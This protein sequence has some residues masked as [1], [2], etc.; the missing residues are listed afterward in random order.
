MITKAKYGL[1]ITTEGGLASAFYPPLYDAVLGLAARVADLDSFLMLKRGFLAVVL[2]LPTA[3]YLLWRRNCDLRA[4]ILVAFLPMFIQRFD[5][6][7]KT[8]E[9][10]SL[11]LSLAW[12]L[13]WLLPLRHI[14][15][16]KEL[17]TAILVGVFAG[18][19]LA[20]YYYYF[21]VYA[22]YLI[23]FD[24]GGE[25]YH[26]RFSRCLERVKVLAVVG[27][28]ALV[29]SAWYWLPLFQD[30]ARFG[31]AS[32]QNRYF[33]ID[34]AGFLQ[35]ADLGLLHVIPIFATFLFADQSELQKRLHYLVLSS[36]AWIALSC[37][38]ALLGFPLLYVKVFLFMQYVGSISLIVGVV[39]IFRQ[40]RERRSFWG[41][42]LESALAPTLV[43][44]ALESLILFQHSPELKT[45]LDTPEPK[46]SQSEQTEFIQ[47][48]RGRTVLTSDSNLGSF[49]PVHIFL[50]TN[51]HYS[52][53][54]ARS[55][56]RLEFLKSLIGLERGHE[57]A[58][59]LSY[60]PFVKVDFVDIRNNGNFV[61][62]RDN[63]PL[64][65]PTIV[66]RF[67]Y[68]PRALQSEWFIK[69]T[70]EIGDLRVDFLRIIP[71]PFEIYKDFGARA[72]KIARDL[73]LVPP[74]R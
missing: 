55:E 32:Y 42:R 10:I 11:Y 62:S 4:A 17:V 53:A 36:F 56:Q 68:V 2:V 27:I 18:L 67:G 24:V 33:P 16:R 20:N 54:A 72:T 43:I 34:L 19:L 64:W 49:L 60:N 35:G 57:L 38:I 7:Y 48:V 21:F 40:S 41:V 31:L 9:I 65:P 45:A 66:E 28:A 30:I 44:V 23:L 26:R 71:P 52:H 15:T 29:A 73:N 50:E 46:F 47:K 59:L 6:L 37:C 61:L 3:V 22:L 74:H 70:W 5:L 1:P 51:Q 8:S 25:L 69:E 13:F 39:E 58:W 12:F 14:K 63:F